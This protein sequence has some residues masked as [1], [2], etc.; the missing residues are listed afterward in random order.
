MKTKID[1]LN[2]VS[3]T[4]LSRRHFLR[5][6]A[7]TCL[8]AGMM[9]ACSGGSSQ[10]DTFIPNNNDLDFKSGTWHKSF[11]GSCI[12]T[13]CGTEIK[14]QNGV[15]IEV[16]GD[17]NHP[18]NKGTLCPRGVSMLKNTYNPYRVKTPM[19]RTN[20]QKGVD[21]D[22]GWVEISWDEAMSTVI[23]ELKAVQEPELGSDP[24]DMMTYMSGRDFRQVAF[25]HGF[26]ANSH[27]SPFMKL[28]EGQYFAGLLTSNY[29]TTAGPLCEVHHAPTK[30]NATFVDRIDLEY[31]DYLV[32]LGRNVGSSVAYASG[33]TR[34]YLDALE[35]G[36]RIVGIDPHVGADIS[37][38]GNQGE[39]V[40]INPSTDM[41]FCMAMLNIILW[42]KKV[43]D[44]DAMRWRATAPYL[45]R[46]EADLTGN[47]N[48]GGYFLREGYV[49]GTNYT[50]E[51]AVDITKAPLV[52][53]VDSIA[54]PYYQYTAADDCA[55]LPSILYTT[56]K[57]WLTN[58]FTGIDS[59]L[60][61]ELQAEYDMIIA[62]TTDWNGEL[63]ETA[64]VKLLK[65]AEA[66]NDSNAS[67]HFKNT[68]E[69]AE[70]ISGI[71][72]D[73]IRQIADDFISASHVNDA[74]STVTITD[75]GKTVTFPKRPAA[76]AVGRGT[77]NDMQGQRVYTL[78]NTIN[79]LVGGMGVPGSIVT[80]SE[81][82][83][84]FEDG[85]VRY[86]TLGSITTERDQLFKLGLSN[87][88][89][90]QQFYPLA[91]FTISGFAMGGILDPDKYGMDY[92]IKVLFIHATNPVMN[93]AS[94]EKS[95]DVLKKVPFVFGVSIQMDETSMF[96]DI[97]LPEHSHYERN[98]LRPI[99]E[100]MAV[101]AETIHLR[102]MN[103]KERAIDLVYNT[104][105]FDDILV[106]IIHGIGKTM[107]LNI[108]YNGF[109]GE[110]HGIHDL[111]TP[112]PAAPPNLDVNTPYT[113]QEM[114]ERVLEAYPATDGFHNVQWY[115]EN[116]FA[117]ANTPK[118]QCYEYYSFQVEHKENGKANDTFPA[119]WR[120]TGRL[121]V[122]NADDFLAGEFLRRNVEDDF[123][124]DIPGWEGKMQEIYNE[125]T[126]VP[127]WFD[128]F[129]AKGH[130]DFDPE[131]DMY[132][133]NWKITIR[134]LGLGGQDDNAWLREIAEKHE[135]DD[136]LYIHIHPEVAEAKGLKNGDRIKVTSRLSK[137]GNR[138]D[139]Y[140]KPVEGIVKITNLIAK[141]CVG[142]PGQGGRIG[143]MV[144]PVC[145]RGS[146]YNVLLSNTEGLI[147]PDSGAVPISVSV[148]I[149]K[150]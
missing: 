79:F 130:P 68:P 1:P 45:I 44:L 92:D 89:K 105:Q 138:Y 76:L 95:V 20:P 21:I 10:D 23:N 47:P 87:S 112:V 98:Q 41:A 51:D 7:A 134:N 143:S 80:A 73:K 142:F 113:Y 90:G 67:G 146:N 3:M 116:G 50:L 122:Y 26:A 24:A 135:F 15:G 108:M 9:S 132:A 58:W 49:L 59:Y 6:T 121:P 93:N 139:G 96:C 133:V 69:W 60:Q 131:Y 53:G 14:V 145:R 114:M 129:A 12:W 55:A 13:N 40:P 126:P 70:Y 30:F 39:W 35:R 109:Y 124:R 127:K 84:T 34:A 147:Q 140:V 104:R 103:Y 36:M 56:D 63:I 11:C 31:C 37:K 82:A 119:E 2:D 144:N 52:M 4:T 72:A 97:L 33:G 101:S 54:R 27:E 137:Q 25:W 85:I 61:A 141:N 62:D 86:H 18:S 100:C 29:H 94:R 111:G 136:S 117:L 107:K 77:A 28:L 46:G 123:G 99:D 5:V 118:W 16:R 125:Y 88:Y 106:D 43:F 149:E 128:N 150:A 115:K 75:R 17:K 57:A 48:R 71:P 65:S 102:G 32:A 74:G 120:R 78:A 8:A 19:K 22:P 91:F 42:E 66:E 83:Y 148:K 38:A 64:F 81:P 110:P